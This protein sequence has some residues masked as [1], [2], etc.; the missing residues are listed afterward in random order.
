VLAGR[1]LYS[2]G[3]EGFFGIVDNGVLESGFD[4]VMV[5]MDWI[6]WR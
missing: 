1:F 5:V 6:N 2:W 3:V 4:G